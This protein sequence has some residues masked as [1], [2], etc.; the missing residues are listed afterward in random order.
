MRRIRKTMYNIGAVI[1]SDS[2]RIGRSV[3]GFIF[4]M[5]LA[6]L[7]CLYSWFNIISNWDPYGSASTSNIKI[8]VVT[9]DVGVNM[10]GLN[11]NIGDSVVEGLHSNTTI[12]WQFPADKDTA[13]EGV[14]SGKYYAALVVPENFTEDLMGFMHGEYSKPAIIYYENDKKNIIAPKITGKAKTAVQETVNSTFI[15]TLAEKL[16]NIGSVISNSGVTVDDVLD[17][18]TGGLDNI[19]SNLRSAIAITDSLISVSQS[20][21]SM[22]NATNSALP[23]VSN[24]L[25]SAQTSLSNTQDR[26]KTGKED[27]VYMDDA[28]K[29]GEAQLK[30]N[31]D[32]LDSTVGTT[33]Y[34]LNSINSALGI[35]NPTQTVNNLNNAINAVNG[36]TPTNTLTQ[37]EYDALNALYRDTRL[38]IISSVGNYDKLIQNSQIGTNLVS[39]ISDLQDTVTN[40]Q[41][42]TG[43]ADGNLTGMQGVLSSYSNALGQTIGSMYGTRENLNDLLTIA[44]NLSNAIND[45]RNSPNYEML[46]NALKLDSGALVKYLSSPVNLETVQLFAIKDYGSAASPFYTILTLWVGGLFNV[47]IMKTEIKPS[48]DLPVLTK[49][50]GFWGRYFLIF[51]IGQLTAMVTGLG[52]L[53]YLGVQCYHPLLYLLAL[54]VADFCITFINYCL[55]YAFGAA[56]LAISVI[57]MCIQVGGSGGTYPVEVLP[58]I[59]Q[60]LY[61]YMPFKYGMNALREVIGGMYDHTYRNCLLTLLL[62]IP[63]FLPIAFGGRLLAKPLINLL[64]KGMK[65]AKI[66][67]E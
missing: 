17:N 16:A 29:N 6:L 32:Q 42:L 25:D 20:A 48:R 66:M 52:N 60:D 8:A 65:K 31:L 56:G 58:Q 46:M 14:Y 15:T 61:R 2:K 5:G 37:Q 62:Y 4:I 18:F 49:W 55:V 30:K 34:D 57:M 9:E 38:Q 54:F 21:Q 59:F 35:T 22:L 11:L 64:N 10:L 43:M 47:V 19:E 24:M 3:V 23:K 44:N 26:L 28:I 7:P 27:V 36:T 53:Y 51:A 33:F 40:L 41:A 39:A 1:R 45:F 63:I 50:E 13:L 12:G 67:A